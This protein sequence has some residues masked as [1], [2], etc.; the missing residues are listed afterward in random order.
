MDNYQ[1]AV[2]GPAGSGKSTI[3]KLIAKQLG[4]IYL[5]TGAMYRALTYVL[6]KEGANVSDS[7]QIEN[8]LDKMDLKIT[9][10][11]VWINGEEVTT[12]IRDP[13]VSHNVSAVAM[14]LKV[15][16]EMKRL[17]R[18]IANVN[19]VIM[20]G[21]DIGT[22]VLPNAKYKFYLVASVEERAKRRLKELLE[23]GHEGDLE[24]IVGEIA[25]RDQLDSEREHAPLKQAEDAILVD[26]TVMSIDEV[27]TTI[28]GHV[29]DEV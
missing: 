14:N 6:L 7:E 13:K 9:P 2:D 24:T 16:E 19:N 3:A 5:D 29:R 1:I 17:Q 15:R 27:V 23:A 11:A 26:T 4:I 8:E 10:D 20:D 22:N 12:Q 25:R 21:R 18:E 28:L